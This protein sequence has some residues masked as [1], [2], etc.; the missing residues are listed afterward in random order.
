M[1]N[2][3][4]F[5]KYREDEDLRKGLLCCLVLPGR[6]TNSEI[7]IALDEYLQMQGLDWSKCVSACMDGVASKAGSCLGVVKKVPHPKVLITSV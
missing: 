2:L 6:N 4:C 5:I 1:S 7:F 3:L